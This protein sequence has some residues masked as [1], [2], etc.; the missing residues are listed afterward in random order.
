MDYKLKDTLLPVFGIYLILAM[1]QAIQMF[2]V[3]P[4]WAFVSNNKSV[5]SMVF[6]GINTVASKDKLGIHCFLVTGS[7]LRARPILNSNGCI[8]KLVGNDKGLISEN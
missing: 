2:L 7:F 4:S 5:T 8:D 3:I 1:E 6:E